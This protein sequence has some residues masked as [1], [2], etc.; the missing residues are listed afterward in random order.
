MRQ[1]GLYLVR[2]KHALDEGRNEAGL[3]S[4]LVPTDADT[5]WVKPRVSCIHRGKPLAQKRTCSHLPESRIR[6]PQRH[7]FYKGSGSITSNRIIKPMS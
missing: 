3:P 4:G 1:L 2:H 7:P 6:G 5:H